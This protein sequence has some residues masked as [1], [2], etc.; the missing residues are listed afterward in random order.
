VREFF[1]DGKASVPDT[2]VLLCRQKDP[3]RGE[4]DIDLGAPFL[5]FLRGE[6]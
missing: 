1:E 6:L 2:R 3:A 4:D 5:G